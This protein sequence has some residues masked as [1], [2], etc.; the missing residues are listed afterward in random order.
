MTQPI[1]ARD[2]LKAI[3]LNEQGLV[4]AIIRMRAQ[5]GC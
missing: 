5:S 2:L 4:P 1:N 3:R